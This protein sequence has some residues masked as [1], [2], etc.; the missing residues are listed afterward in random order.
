MKDARAHLAKMRELPCP[1]E[2]DPNYALT[3]GI[4]VPAE[5]L[6]PYPYGPAGVLSEGCGRNVTH[7]WDAF[8]SDAYLTLQRLMI[9]VDA[10]FGEHCAEGER[11][12]IAREVAVTLGRLE[13]RYKGLKQEEE[14]K[15]ASR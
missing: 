7:R 11:P 1:R 8:R 12:E 2:E 15:A 13:A 14:E 6:W 10:W 5:S 3:C 4:R 9:E